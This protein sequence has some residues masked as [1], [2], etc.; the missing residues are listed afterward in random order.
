MHLIVSSGYKVGLWR[1][2]GWVANG[3]GVE[4]V[5]VHGGMGWRW[6]R[7]RGVSGDRLFYNLI[8]FEGLLCN[9]VHG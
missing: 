8:V 5:A 6:W 1:R 7:K 3:D 9:V 2:V 4:W